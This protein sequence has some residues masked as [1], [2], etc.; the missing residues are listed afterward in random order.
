MLHVKS[1]THKQSLDLVFPYP[2][3]ILSIALTSLG[4]GRHSW[5]SVNPLGYVEELLAATALRESFQTEQSYINIIEKAKIEG[6]RNVYTVVCYPWKAI[7]ITFLCSMLMPYPNWSN[8]HSLLALSF[9]PYI[10]SIINPAD[11]E[12]LL[13]F[14]TQKL[15]SHSVPEGL[16]W[17]LSQSSIPQVYI[18]LPHSFQGHDLNFIPSF[19]DISSR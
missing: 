9:S 11:P 7:H 14:P 15:V 12:I 1:H 2:I 10:W 5:V 4:S 17:L 6:C 18:S 13:S 8:A 19:L 3:S 16:Q